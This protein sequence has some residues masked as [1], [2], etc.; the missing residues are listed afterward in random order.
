MI[1][2]QQQNSVKNVNE[3]FI[4]DNISANLNN[5]IN[6]ECGQVTQKGIFLTGMNRGLLSMFIRAITC[7]YIFMLNNTNNEG[8]TTLQ[9]QHE[10]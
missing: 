4:F 6:D 2:D 1:N 3:E 10:R 8:D 9:K 5:Q 7:Q